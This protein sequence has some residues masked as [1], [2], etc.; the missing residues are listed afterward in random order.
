LPVIPNIPKAVSSTTTKRCDKCGRILPLSQ[1]SRAHSE[2]Y[3]DGFIPWCNECVAERIDRAGGNWE[4]IDRLC[5]WAGIPFIV[6]EWERIKEMTLPSETWP[7]YAKI[8]A[9]DDYVSLGWSDYF[10][11]YK[12]LKE[13]GLIEE[14]LPEIRE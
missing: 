14:E 9:T 6:K 5:M 2:F 7:T 10:R 1:F 11:Q 3:S 4:I 12:K 13:V 8:F